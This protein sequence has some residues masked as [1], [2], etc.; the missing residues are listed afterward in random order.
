MEPPTPPQPVS[1]TYQCGS[2]TVIVNF[3]RPVRC[4]TIAGDGS[5]FQFTAPAGAPTITGATG[6]GCS[7]PGATATTQIQL[8]LSGPLT[9]NTTYTL[10]IKQGTDGNTLCGICTGAGSCLANPSDFNIPVPPSNGNV[11]I[12]P[13]N[14]TICRGQTVT[15]TAN[16]NLTVTNY[17]W[18]ANGSCTGTPFASGAGVNQVNVSPTNTTTYCVRASF[19]GGC[20]D[21]TATTTVNVNRAPTACF[22]PI[23]NPFC[24]GQTVT[25]DPSCSQYVK[26]CGGSCVLAC[27]DPCGSWPFIVPCQA[28]ACGHFSYWILPVPPYFQAQGPGASSLNSI[29]VTFPSPGEYSVQF[30]LCEPFQG[31]CH[32]VTQRYTV[33]CV[34]SGLDVD[35]RAERVGRDVRLHWAV[36]ASDSLQRFYILRAARTHLTYD[37]IATLEGQQYTYMDRDLRPNS[38]LYKV[39]QELPSGGRL[40][41]EAVEVIVHPSSEAQVWVHGVSAPVGEPILVSWIAPDATSLTLT[42]YDAAGRQLHAHQTA[43]PEGSHLIPSPGTSGVYLLQATGSDFHRTYRLLWY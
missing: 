16:A 13:N 5:D 33:T 4:N 9:P 21:A 12:T 28:A 23:P 42:L 20:G 27:D 34:L 36:N 39:V 22:N 38:Y 43:S 2:N 15:L 10:R 3:D 25:L 31:C 19:G 37:T 14:P 18:Y 7:A 32:T 40:E 41:S 35:L 26:S 8:T 6:I 11:S 24:A 30:T 17:Q 1:F 29:N